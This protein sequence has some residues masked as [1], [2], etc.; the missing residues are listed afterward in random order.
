MKNY[1]K[2]FKIMMVVL[3]LV[4]VAILV[5]GWSVGFESNDGQAVDVLILWAYIMLGLALA[6]A[7]VV[8]FL[9]GLSND[10][11]GML[12]SLGLVVVAAAAVIG[13]AYAL[14][15]GNPAVALTTEQPSAM[16]LKLTD[17]ILNLTYFLGGGAIVAIVLGEI[18]SAI[19][20]R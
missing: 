8:S 10:A 17:T 15:P 4:S 18:V 5:W 13:L 6:G 16:T 2:I 12:K 20:N 9:V 11:K 3:L 14:A 7:L 19:K 1:G